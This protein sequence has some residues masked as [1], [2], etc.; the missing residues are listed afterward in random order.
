M[1]G[2]DK[3]PDAADD[4]IDLGG[5][6]LDDGTHFRFRWENHQGEAQ[7]RLCQGARRD[8]E[9]RP[10][11]GKPAFRL[12]LCRHCI[13]RDA[14]VPALSKH[15]LSIRQFCRFNG[16]KLILVTKLGHES[17]A[18]EEGEYPVALDR[19][20]AMGSSL[21][22]ARRYNWAAMCGVGSRRMITPR[23]PTGKP[24]QKTKAKARESKDYKALAGLLDKCQRRGLPE[25]VVKTHRNRIE[26]MPDDWRKS[27]RDHYAHLLGGLT[28]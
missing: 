18:F 21:T 16:D 6:E 15:G 5:G 27:L 4:D 1:S 20:Q 3:M 10:K 7:C 22:Y 19:P 17:G 9:R 25:A 8:A 23:K 24:T 13:I 12:T 14:T 26:G 11:Q 28:E 2:E